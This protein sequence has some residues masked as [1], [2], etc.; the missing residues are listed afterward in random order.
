MV[1]ATLCIIVALLFVSVVVNYT[2][3]DHVTAYVHREPQRECK[4]TGSSENRSIEC[5]Y[6]IYTNDEVF[7][8]TDNIWFFKFNSADITNR[9]RVGETYCFKVNGFRVP[10]LSWFRNV[11]SVKPGACPS[12]S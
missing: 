12:G 8:N 10:F 6:K 5:A 9:L 3:V 2:S 7:V 11:I 1:I 4:S